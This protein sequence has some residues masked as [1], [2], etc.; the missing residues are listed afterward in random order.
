MVI[1]EIPWSPLFWLSIAIVSTYINLQLTLSR[2]RC[3]FLV[4]TWA[5]VLSTE[6]H[7]PPPHFNMQPFTA[8]WAILGILSFFRIGTQ[9]YC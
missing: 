1:F 5:L 4:L 8:K 3:Q 6:T 7:F 9:E 2:R